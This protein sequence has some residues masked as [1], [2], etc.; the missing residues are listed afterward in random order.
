MVLE[1]TGRTHAEG[2]ESCTKDGT[3]Q[4]RFGIHVFGRSDGLNDLSDDTTAMD[5]VSLIPLQLK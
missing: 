3:K 4:R 1:V 5:T 2:T